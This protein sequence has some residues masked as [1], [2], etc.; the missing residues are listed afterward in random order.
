MKVMGALSKEMDLSGI[1]LLA[2]WLFSY[3]ARESAHWLIN[4]YL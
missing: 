3:N 2:E 1:V 4:L